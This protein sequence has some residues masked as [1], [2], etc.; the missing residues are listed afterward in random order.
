MED[1]IT[2]VGQEIRKGKGQAFSFLTTDSGEKK[3]GVRQ[4]LS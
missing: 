3:L 4:E 1:S 2:V